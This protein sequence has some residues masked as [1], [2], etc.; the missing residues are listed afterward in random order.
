MLTINNF[1]FQFKQQVLF[2]DLN[3][4]FKDHK[5]SVILGSSG[6]GKSTLLRIL[7]GLVKSDLNIK[8][9]NL[10][11]VFQESNLLPW[12]SVEKNIALPFSL[13]QKSISLDRIN[14]TLK[15]VGLEAHA[16]KR[17]HELSGGMKMRACMARALITNPQ[18]LFLDEP[19]SALDELTRLDMQDLLL[20]LQVKHKMTVLLVTHSLTEAAYLADEIFCINLETHQL[21]LFERTPFS[22]DRNSHEYHQQVQK[23]TEFFQKYR[24]G[25]SL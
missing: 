21:D 12:L 3:V 5:I 1:N 22:K 15:S 24:G 17:P 8:L 14:A 23:L 19:F 4:T 10:S 13:A 9:S 2:K 7:S 16:Q 11:F 18:Y 25:S 20:Q 6:S